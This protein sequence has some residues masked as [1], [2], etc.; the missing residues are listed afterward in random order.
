MKSCLVL[1]DLPVA[2]QVKNFT[3]KNLSLIQSRWDEIK[4]AIER[5]VKLMNSF[6]ID[7]ENLTS[8][9]ALIPIIYYLFKNPQ[10]TVLTGSSFDV[11]NSTNIR[12]WLCMALLNNIFSGQS[13][14]MLTEVRRVL[15]NDSSNRI[16]PAEEVNQF[17]VGI[18]SI[19]PFC[20]IIIW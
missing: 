6:G 5:S 14:N 20:S 16:F 7:C 12:K 8:A 10:M 13:D 1:T 9:N 4:S 3:N 17:I 19:I 18:I 15:I 2:Y 11:Q